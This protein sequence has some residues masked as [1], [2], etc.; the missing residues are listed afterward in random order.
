MKG[1]TMHRK[2]AM[3]TV[4]AVLGVIGAGAAVAGQPAN[5]GCF[6]TNR[7]AYVETVALPDETAPGA[8]EVGAILADRASDNGTINRDYKTGCGG[9]PSQ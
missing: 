1:A 5:P 4:L 7:A 6:G 9:N 3:F 8:S 2:L